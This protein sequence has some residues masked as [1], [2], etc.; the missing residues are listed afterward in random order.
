[1]VGHRTERYIDFGWASAKL[2]DVVNWLPARITALLIAA[3]AFFVK[4]ADAE[5]AW[6]VAL[7]DAKMHDSPN[8]GW[9]EAALAGALGFALGG[10]RACDGKVHDLPTF[11]GGRTDLTPKD[12]TRALKLYEAMLTVLFVVTLVVGGIVWRLS[13]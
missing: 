6:R 13:V 3:A 11:G 4:G 5:A 1:M 12:I 2:D 7:R 9:P 10:P 8:A